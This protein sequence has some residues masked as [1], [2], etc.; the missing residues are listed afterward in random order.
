MYQKIKTIPKNHKINGYEKRL[1]K[2]MPADTDEFMVQCN[3][4]V[5]TNE[6]RP[7]WL[8]TTWIK[9]KET[10]YHIKYFTYYE[11]WLYDY[12]HSWGQCDVFCYRVLNPMIEK[13]PQLFKNVIKWAKS[14]KVYVKRASAVCLLH[15]SQSFEVNVGFDLVKQI[16]NILIEDKHL[17]VQKGIGWLLKYAYIAYP[18]ETIQYL[19]DNISIM[20]RTTFRYALEKMNEELKIELMSL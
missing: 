12:I 17:H 4:L 3:K 15:S 19:K 10:P 18:T 7:F 8:V 2:E 14:D 16:L 5:E 20:S 11:R 1:Y 13:Y 9:R 6:W